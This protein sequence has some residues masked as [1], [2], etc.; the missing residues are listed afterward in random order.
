MRRSA[1]FAAASLAVA[2]A[3]APALAGPGAA[4]GNVNLRAEPS[5]HARK[6]ATIP[7]GAAVEIIE[8]PR[9][10]KVAYQGRT[11]WAS[12]KYIA[13]ASAA[14]YGGIATEYYGPRPRI[15]YRGWPPFYYDIPFHRGAEDI[16]ANRNTYGPTVPLYYNF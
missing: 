4:T 2:L 12:A 9:W 14:K 1:I 11:G 15:Y 6:L 3:A 10:C 5:A 16:H 7:A 8:C 13:A